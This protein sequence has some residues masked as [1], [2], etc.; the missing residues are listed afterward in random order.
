MKTHN[1]TIALSMPLAIIL[2]I[3]ALRA[4]L[5]WVK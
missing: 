3:L 2:V 1:A 4:L 5:E